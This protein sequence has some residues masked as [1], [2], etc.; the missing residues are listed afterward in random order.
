MSREITTPLSVRVSMD[1]ESLSDPPRGE[2]RTYGGKGWKKRESN[3][4]PLRSNKGGKQR[5]KGKKGDFHA[6]IANTDNFLD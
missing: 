4:S 6:T 3:P 2:N 1:G 5:G